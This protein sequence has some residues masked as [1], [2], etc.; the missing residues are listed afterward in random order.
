MERKNEARWI[1]VRQRW[2]INIQAEGERRTFTSSTPGR[3][4]KVEAERKADKWMENRLIGE[5]TR[6][7]V[8]LKSYLEHLKK[9]TSPSHWRQY[10]SH[11][12]LYIQP[13]IGVKRV[14]RITKRDLQEVLDDAYNSSTRFPDRKLSEKSLKNIRACMASFICYCRDAGTTNLYPDKL[15]IPSGAKKPAKTILLPNELNTL[16]S[17]NTTIY[18]QKRRQDVY[19]HAYRFEVLTGLRVGEIVGLQHEDI[20]GS[21]MTIHRAINDDGEIT[22]GKNANAKRTQELSDLALEEL[23]A[24]AEM[25]KEAGGISK[26]IFPDLRDMGFLN[27]ELYRKSWARYCASNRIEHAKTP[28]ELRHTFVSINDEMPEGLK[29]SVMGH[30]L[31]MDTEGIYGHERQDAQHRAAGYIDKAFSEALKLRKVEQI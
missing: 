14:G 29:K 9:T 3:K 20:D 2:Q 12:R 17:E 22:H 8:L 4:G 10:E 31:S 6:V 15:K 11:I 24:Q 1:E 25:L 16:F 30:S 26:Y 18:H 21:R 19:I 5:N 13:I 27:Q 28:Y 7:S 23:S